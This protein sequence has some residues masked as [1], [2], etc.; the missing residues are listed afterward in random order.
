MLSVAGVIS[1]FLMF[2]DSL[3]QARAAT[4]NTLG[5]SRY[6]TRLNFYIYEISRI[7]HVQQ[8]GL[9]FYKFLHPYSINLNK[10]NYQNFEHLETTL[11]SYV[12][13]KKN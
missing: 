9:H 1:F 7:I 11:Y 12:F 4:R 3:L 2:F 13:Y 10:M 8:K 6:N 5:I